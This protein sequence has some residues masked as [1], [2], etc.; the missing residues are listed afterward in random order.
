MTKK[1]SDDHFVAQT[2][3]KG[4]G[5][6]SSIPTAPSVPGCCW[7]LPSPGCLQIH[8]GYFSISWRSWCIVVLLLVHFVSLSLRCEEF[9]LQAPYGFWPKQIPH[10]QIQCPGFYHYHSEVC[11]QAHTDSPLSKLLH[12]S[13]PQ[14]QFV[15]GCD[16]LEAVILLT[17]SQST[18]GRWSPCLSEFLLH[19]QKW[20]RQISVLLRK[21]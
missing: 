19:R 9:I 21:T 3:L 17:V 14:S 20:S 6:V 11:E 8:R 13:L 12:S 4:Q 7:R 10:Y 16:H 1:F 5:S 2:L 15:M 18:S